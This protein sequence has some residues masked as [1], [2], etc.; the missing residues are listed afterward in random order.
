MIRLLIGLYILL[1]TITSIAS[2]SYAWDLFGFFSSD[3]KEQTKEEVPITKEIIRFHKPVIRTREPHPYKHLP[4]IVKIAIIIDDMGMDKKR[5]N[6]FIKMNIPLTLAFLPYA[7][8]LKRDTKRAIDNGHE[9]M[10]HMPMEP[11]NSKVSLGGIGLKDNMD[12]LDIDVELFQAFSSFNGYVG[13]NNHMGSKFTQNKDSMAAVMQRLKNKDL[14]FIDSVTISTSVAL[15]EAKKVG[16]KSASRDVF[17]DHEDTIEFARKALKRLERTAQKN[18]HAIAIG[19][20]KDSTIQALKEWV[21]TLDEKNI[22]LVHASEL[23]E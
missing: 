5:G 12:L 10:I 22:K 3:K 17:L 11:L 14:Y 8:G 7:E 18:G 9:L 20:P 1:V 16:L 19:H 13:L 15:S 4:N 21:V 2:P 23:V 6:E